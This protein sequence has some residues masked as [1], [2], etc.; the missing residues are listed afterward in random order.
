[1]KK[2]VKKV[3]NRLGYEL[4]KKD[5]VEFNSSPYC[6]LTKVKE[7]VDLDRLSN[8]NESIQGMTTK[9]SGKFLFSLCYMQELNGDVVEVGSWQGKSASYLARATKESKNGDFYAIDHFKGNKGKEDLYSTGKENYSSKEAFTDNMEKIG[10]T[11]YVHL[12]DMKNTDASEKLQK[13]KIR[14]LFID[15]DHTRKG[16]EKD[17][18]LFFPMLTKGSIVVFDDYFNGF[19]GLVQAIEKLLQDNDFSRV[20]YY[21]HTLVVKV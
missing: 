15:G 4:V 20:F 8:I 16:V 21:R 13:N 12:L 1:M 14:F 6:Q 5:K 7:I 3:I 18:E 9:E 2:I 19:P 11:K 17:I 10:L